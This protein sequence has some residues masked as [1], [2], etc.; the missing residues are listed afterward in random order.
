MN[1]FMRTIRTAAGGAMVAI[2]GTSVGQAGS[3]PA[4]ADL[5]KPV[6][7][8][9]EC[10]LPDGSGLAFGGNEQAADD[11]CART[12]IREGDTWK[13][14]YADLSAANPLQKHQ[15][16]TWD[17][18][19]RLKNA[20]SRARFAFFQGLPAAE[21]QKMLKAQA[22]PA[23]EGVLKDLDGL[24][25]ELTG[26]KLA[27][28]EAGQIK[29]AAPLLQSAVGKIRPAAAAL[30]NGVTAE[31]LK[32]L[33]EAQIDM[34]KAAEALDAEPPARALSPLVY[35]EKTKL[36][37]LFGG[38]HLDY[39]TNDTWI[40][41]P[42]KK[43]WM[44]KHPAGA[45]SPR[46]NH[47]LKAAAG[48]V[49]LS[50]GYNYTSTTDYMGGQY[51]D[52]KD[53]DWTYDVAA[54][55]WT[56]GQIEPADSRQYRKNPYLPEFFT[57]GEKPSAAAF[58][59]KLKAMPA[60]TWVLPNPPYTP[61]QNRDWGS[62]TIDTDRDMLLFWSGGHCAHGGSDVLQYHFA[63]NRWELA[64]PVEFPLGQLYSNTSYPDTF[65]FNRRPWVTG[66]TYLNY[67]YDPTARKLLFTG[68]GKH[69]YVYDPDIAEWTARFDKPAGMTYGGCFYDLNCAA[70]AGGAVCWTKEGRIFRFDAGAGQWVEAKV[71]GKL[72]GA[73]VDTSTSVYDAKRDRLLIFAGSYGQKYSGQ[74][75]ALDLKTMTAS[76]LSPAN[77]SAVPAV[78]G[79]G[80]DRA[81]YDIANDLALMGTLLPP[82][83]DGFQRT[84]AFDCAG[85][86]WLSLKLGYETAG[87]KKTPVT[88]RGHSSGIVFDPKRKLVWGVDS[89]C[90]V[91]V[92]RLDVKNADPI[93]MANPQ[94]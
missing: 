69:C 68:H 2:L 13:A 40:F 80:T 27:E 47:Q 78:G 55:A 28:Y 60:N 88:P 10:L 89:N 31:E 22:V 71:N 3:A 21:E 23:I 92:L 14:V 6:L 50:G 67:V 19:T 43:K 5:G 16:R 74:V 24:I 41:D 66:H 46:G 90:R 61:R 75:H 1:K 82:D 34:E 7:W 91:Y 25:A 48:T 73:S 63:A 18:R 8:G 62:V 93:V 87:D 9:S 52:V 77:M 49:T 86:R 53:G 20:A 12:R 35:D 42:I 72:P 30:A 58:V 57:Q 59:E 64:F 83:A 39:L 65:N 15:V 32:G 36:F 33:R 17:L 26:L 54:N 11:G 85:N 70:A 38:D 51:K 4:P 84:P 56:G 44:Q 37:V 79:F 76:A 81:C 29:F 94:P 45:P